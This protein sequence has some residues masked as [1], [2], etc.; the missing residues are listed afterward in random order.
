[1]KYAKGL[2]TG[3]AGGQRQGQRPRQPGL[4]AGAPWIPDKLPDAPPEESQHYVKDAGY[5]R[6]AMPGSPLR[7][8]SNP[9]PCPRAPAEAQTDKGWAATSVITRTIASRSDI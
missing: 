6:S 5:V 2:R 4:W 8:V 9:G 1:M 7:G 3:Q